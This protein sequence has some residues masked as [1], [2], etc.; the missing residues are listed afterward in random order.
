MNVNKLL[1]C[2]GLML[3]THDFFT[4]PEKKESSHKNSGTIVV[5]I[6]GQTVV[7]KS[8]IGQKVQKKLQEEQEHLSKPLQ[9]DE[10]RI[11]IKEQEL[12][13]KKQELDKDA[14]EITN[15]KLLSQD[16]KQRKF[17][18]LQDRVRVLEEDKAELERLAKRLQ[19]DAKRLEGKM[20]Q[21]YQEE[22]SKLDV[23]IRDIIKDVAAREGWDIVLMEEAVVYA[24]P[25]VS[26]TDVIIKELD[27]LDKKNNTPKSK[28]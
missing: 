10:K 26:K 11:R 25:S 4:S 17:E 7:Q 8:K 6:S 23:Q 18:G 5:T 20:S 12:L 1:L 13:K 24:A 19:A 2:A 15:N 14:E 28:L 21:L 27:E 9:E 3:V 22:M 16:A